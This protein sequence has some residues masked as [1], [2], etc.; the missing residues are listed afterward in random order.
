MCKKKKLKKF[1]VNAQYYRSDFLRPAELDMVNVY[2]N[3]PKKVWKK[4][5]KK[6]KKYEKEWQLGYF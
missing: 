5:K 6:L 2:M 1:S 4:L 3:I